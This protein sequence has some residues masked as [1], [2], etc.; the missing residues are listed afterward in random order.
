MGAPQPGDGD[1]DSEFARSVLGLLGTEEVSRLL[2]RALQLAVLRTGA[3][4]AYVEVLTEEGGLEVSNI[5]TEGCSAE[6]VSEIQALVSRGIIAEAIASGRTVESANAQ[7]DPRFFE[8]ESVQRH[9]IEAVLCVPINTD[10]VSGAI[11]LQGRRAGGPFSFAADARADIETLAQ[12][13]GV[14]VRRLDAGA[15]R[16]RRGHDPAVVPDAFSSIICHSPALRDVLDKLRF[17]APLDVHVLLTGPSG[18]G[19]TQLAHATHMGSRRRGRPFVELNCAAVPEN[20]LENELFGAEPGAHSAVPKQGLM[21]KVEAAE[22]GTLFLDEIAELP[23]LAQSKV[24]Q[25]LQSKTYYRLGGSKPRTAD[26]R[27]MAATN[28]HLKQAIV[29]KR[30]REDLYFRLKVLEVKVPPLSERRED[31]VPLARHFLRAASARHELGPKVLS[32]GALR[33]IQTTEWT[34][35]VRELAHQVEAAALVAEQRGSNRV[36]QEDVFPNP[37]GAV[38][39]E[40][41]P[42]SLHEATRSFQ[43]KH[44]LGVLEVT[45]WNVAEAARLLDIS[46]PHLYTLVRSLDLK[47]DR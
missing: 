42:R 35:N 40:Q 26:I 43:R 8:M 19:K 37:P 31:V 2:E 14:T 28:V 36:E 4:E 13:I 29:E 3:R 23:L 10:D 34:G 17:A 24:L 46:R 1:A 15:P 7:L 30:F 21:G 18:A 25:L 20:L 5:A 39:P 22:G 33:A 9:A 27:V 44:I 11:Y 12:V 16:S 45:S 41:G 47:R 6:R 32:P 38:A